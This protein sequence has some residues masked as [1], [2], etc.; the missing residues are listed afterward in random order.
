MIREKRLGKTASTF[1]QALMVIPSPE[2]RR[3]WEKTIEQDEREQKGMK[4]A[5]GMSSI[6]VHGPPHPHVINLAKA[7][8]EAAASVK[9]NIPVGVMQK[10][11]ASDLPDAFAELPPPGEENNGSSQ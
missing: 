11:P 9:V 4:V 5:R 10:L 6:F 7:I 2:E 8:Q 3:Q 1:K